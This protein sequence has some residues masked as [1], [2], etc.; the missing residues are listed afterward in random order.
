M[1]LYLCQKECHVEREGKHLTFHPYII[2]AELYGMAY[3]IMIGILHYCLQGLCIAGT[4]LALLR[5]VYLKGIFQHVGLVIVN[6]VLLHYSHLIHI[7]GLYKSIDSIWHAT[8][9][10]IEPQQLSHPVVDSF[11]HWCHILEALE[12]IV[13]MLLLYAISPKPLLKIHRIH[14]HDMLKPDRNRSTTFLF[15]LF[16]GLISVDTKQ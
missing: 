14:C 2:V 7:I 15:F 4:G 10:N 9:N 16:F 5:L 13:C 11:H 1:K 12:Q 8:N 3:M 6:N